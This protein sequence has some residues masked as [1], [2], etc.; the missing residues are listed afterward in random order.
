[1]TSPNDAISV[2]TGAIAAALAPEE[3]DPVDLTA[4]RKAVVPQEARDLDRLLD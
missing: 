1:M 2:K 3:L 4:I